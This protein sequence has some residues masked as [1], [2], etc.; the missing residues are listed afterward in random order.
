MTR[1]SAWTADRPWLWSWVGAALLW[2]AVVAIAAGEGAGQVL[3]AAL[4]FGVFFVVVAIGQ[5]FVIA[6]GPGNIDLSI[7]SNIALSGSVAMIVMAGQDGLILPGLAEATD[8]S[9]YAAESDQQLRDVYSDLQ[10]S[11]GWTTEAR[12]IT[13]L[14]AGAALAAALLAALASLLWFSRLP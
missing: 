10:S 9:S 13:N 4:S 5:M 7:P 12:E 3:T 8:G 1:I 2:L 6:M 14:V 11:I